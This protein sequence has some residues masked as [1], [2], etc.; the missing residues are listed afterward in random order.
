MH[1]FNGVTVHFCNY[2]FEL[3]ILFHQKNTLP[4]TKATRRSCGLAVSSRS[5][6]LSMLI[7][8][9]LY[10]FNVVCAARLAICRIALVS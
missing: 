7:S 4:V 8:I 9:G 5:R 6:D 3:S 10:V 1:F 2:L